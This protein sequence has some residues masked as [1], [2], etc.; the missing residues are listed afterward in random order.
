MMMDVEF[1]EEVEVKISGNLRDDLR[2]IKFPGKQIA[3][4]SSSLRMVHGLNFSFRDIAPTFLYRK[5]IIQFPKLD[6]SEIMETAVN[7]LQPLVY[8]V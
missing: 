3:P 1:L 6:K 5:S 7:G 2:K 4:K 8:L